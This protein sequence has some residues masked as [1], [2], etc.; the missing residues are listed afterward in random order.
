MGYVYIFI[1][2]I[3]CLWSIVLV[4]G[5]VRTFSIFMVNGISLLKFEISQFILYRIR[6]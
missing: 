5:W 4:Y 6:V 2:H 1:F 3:Q